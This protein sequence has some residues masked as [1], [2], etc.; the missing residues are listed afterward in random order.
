MEAIIVIPKQCVFNISHVLVFQ[1]V[2]KYWN[3]HLTANN[4]QK[5]K[6]VFLIAKFEFMLVRYS[7]WA[8]CTQLWP[9]N[10]HDCSI[11]Q[12]KL[13]TINCKHIHVYY[14]NKCTVFI[15]RKI[16]KS[17]WETKSI[18]KIDYESILKSVDIMRLMKVR[19]EHVK[20]NAQSNLLTSCS[21]NL[22][23]CHSITSNDLSFVPLFKCC[24]AC[25][26]WSL[27]WL[28]RPIQRKKDVWTAFSSAVPLACKV[29]ECLE[30][31]LLW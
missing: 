19:I 22:Q 31:I 5:W 28:L 30:G 7:L 18:L 27:I 10:K 24:K 29:S 4:W 6:I 1:L 15:F 25:D 8:K 23:R 14:Q 16:S 13:L 9:L 12:T 20:C 11:P 2:T 17:V 3:I 21:P 26:E